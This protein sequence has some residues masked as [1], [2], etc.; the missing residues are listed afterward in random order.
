NYGAAMGG[1]LTLWRIDPP[2]GC[3]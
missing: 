3:S 2:G 1:M